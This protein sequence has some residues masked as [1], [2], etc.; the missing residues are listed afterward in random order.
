MIGLDVVEGCVAQARTRFADN[1]NLQFRCLDVQDPAFVELRALRPDSVVCLNVLEHVRD[2]RLALEHMRQVLA[3]GGRAVFLLPA[4]ESLYGPIDQNLGHFRRYS[5]AS[6]GATL[7][8]VVYYGFIM[9]KTGLAERIAYYILSLFPGTYGGILSA[10]FLIGLLLAYPIPSMTVRT[11][12]MAPIAWSLV[13]TLG[14]APRSRGSALIMVT[15]V[16]MAVVPGLAFELGS[17][18][19]PIV[20]RMFAAK[21]IPLS[22]FGYIQV[23]TIPDAGDV[24]GLSWRWTRYGIQ[25][26]KRP[27]RA[28]RISRR[29]SCGRWAAG[30]RAGADH[31]SGGL[32]LDRDVGDRRQVAP[33]CRRS[34]WECSDCW[35]CALAGILQDQR[36]SARACPGRCCLLA[37]RDLQR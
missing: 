3:P 4:F 15:V 5:K 12:I 31:G 18:N 7:L 14:L 28:S 10:F 17:L 22:Q 8:V 26:G 27:I 13:Q 11:A 23:M 20:V 16:E 30:K 35:Y 1:T 6:L 33:P 25:A 29:A 24:R 34:W 36:T 37:G 19:G 21:N 9:K 2:D 32:G